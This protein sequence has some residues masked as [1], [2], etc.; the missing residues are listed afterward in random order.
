M[1][2]GVTCHVLLAGSPVLCGLPISCL[3]PTFSLSPLED[4]AFMLELDSVPMLPLPGAS[5]E[6]LQPVPS[7]WRMVEEQLAPS[8]RLEVKAILGDDAVER[9]LELH[10]EVQTLLEF[11]RELQSGHLSPEQSPG[12]AADSWAL[13]AAPPHLKELVR[14]EIRLLLIGLQQKALQEGRDQ[15]C[16]IAKYSPHVVTF[17]LKANVGNSRPSGSKA[18]IRPLSS[19]A[20]NDLGPFCNKLNI[21]HIGE[22]SSR[23]RT[24]LEEE[25]HALERYIPYLQ[26]HLEEVHW[27]ATELPQATHEPTMAEL[28]EEKRAMERD[29]KLSQPK[30]CPSPSLMAKQLGNSS[31]QPSCLRGS[32]MG[33][34]FV[35]I[36]PAPNVAPSPT[37]RDQTSPLCHQMP[38]WRGHAAKGPLGRMHQDGEDSNH[39]RKDSGTQLPRPV[40]PTPPKGDRIALACR[41]TV[42]GLNSAFHPMPPPEP[43][44]MPRFC[45]HT[46]LLRCQGPS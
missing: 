13:L 11:Y 16:A 17:A 6:P 32:A 31:Y 14:E 44:P 15:D 19:R 3:T 46:R 37:P 23:L 30:P 18:F 4:Q 35:E 43:C 24:L 29:L 40:V 36:S 39:A 22:V 34:N 33:P 42:P 7:L 21:A 1:A 26:S 12:Q 41:T 8:E 27:Q 2:V 10:A 5:G 25:C 20:A 45:P 28:Q 9:N 38:L